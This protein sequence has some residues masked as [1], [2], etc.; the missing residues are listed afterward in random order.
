MNKSV[1]GKEYPH[2]TYE[3]TREMILKY[4]RV[5]EDPNPYFNDEEADVLYAPHTLIGAYTL[6]LAPHIMMDEELD[7]DVSKSVIHTHQMHEY[8]RQAVAGDVLTIRGRIADIKSFEDHETITF[9]GD[10]I[11][12]DGNQVVVAR[13]TLKIGGGAH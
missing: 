13:S 5:V 8:K 1:I 12:Q 11:D 6:L 10:I 4:S 9:E 7:M 2:V 3:L